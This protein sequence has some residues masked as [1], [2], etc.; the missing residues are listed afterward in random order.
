MITLLF[1]FCFQVKHNLQYDAAI[2]ELS[3][4][5]KGSS[6]AI[7]EESGL[8]LKSAIRHILSIDLRDDTIF[9]SCG[10]LF[11]FTSEFSGLGG[12]VGLVKNDA[13]VQANYSLLD[14]V[15]SVLN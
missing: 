1:F 13:F 5:S 3:V 11:Q 2:R 12:N 6:F 10:S 7:R 15:V 14:D 9:P 4:L 8:T